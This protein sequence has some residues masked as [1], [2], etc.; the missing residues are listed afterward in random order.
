MTPQELKDS[1]LWEAIQGKLTIQN[2]SE[3][4]WDIIGSV[5][6][7]PVHEEEVYFEIPER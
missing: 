7:S 1:I 4:A 6:L 2:D 3:S 5:K